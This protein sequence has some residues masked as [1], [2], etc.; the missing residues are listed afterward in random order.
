MDISRRPLDIWVNNSGERSMIEIYIWRS[1]AERFKP[2]NCWRAP[3]EQVSTEKSS[4]DWAMGHF[5]VERRNQQWSEMEWFCFVCFYWWP[6]IY[7]YVLRAYTINET[8]P[9]PWVAFRKCIKIIIWMQF[10]NYKK[11]CTCMGP[12][13]RNTW[14]R[15]RRLAG[16]LG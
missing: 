7:Q 2:W 11:T 9:C 13:N 4:N 14:P 8:N 3:G 1:S 10:G 15:L 6:A 5:N 12:G 16:F